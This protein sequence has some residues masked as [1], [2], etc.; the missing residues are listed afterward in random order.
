MISLCLLLA[1]NCI[2]SHS[3]KFYLPIFEAPRPEIRLR[4]ILCSF[5]VR[6]RCQISFKQWILYIPFSI[7]RH[8]RTSLGGLK[9]S[10]VGQNSCELFWKSSILLCGCIGKCSLKQLY[11]QLGLFMWAQTPHNNFCYLVAFSWPVLTDMNRFYPVCARPSPPLFR[12]CYTAVT[13]LLR[14]CYAAVTLLLRCCYAAVTHRCY[15]PLLQ[16]H[17]CIYRKVGIPV[18]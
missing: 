2:F 9:S 10:S 5:L 3:L 14:C 17:P 6:K 4:S 16:V 18:S 1:R 8:F 12:R 11:F 15:P 13:L 7:S